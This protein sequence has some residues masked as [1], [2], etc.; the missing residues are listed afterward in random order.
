M[1]IYI[2]FWVKFVNTKSWTTNGITGTVKLFLHLRLSGSENRGAGRGYV[3]T[4][5]ERRQL[6]HREA[7]SRPR[8]K[9]E[10][11]GEKVTSLTRLV[12]DACAC[13]YL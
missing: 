1:D 7:K 4:A 10:S 2:D 12:A 8:F 3:E 9:R 13:I 5:K 6:C 11:P